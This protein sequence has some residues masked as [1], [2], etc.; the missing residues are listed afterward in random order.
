[1]TEK[2]KCVQGLL[3]NA[4]YDKELIN[5]RIACKD[6]CLEYNGLKNSDADGRRKA[7]EKIIG[8]IKENICIE[9]SFWC[10]YGYNIEVGENFYA[11]HN[12]IILD[13]AKVKFGDNVFIG[14]NCSFYTAGHPLDVQQRNEGLE[15]AHPI[16]VGNNV[17]FGG[18]VVVLPGVSIGNNSVI[19]AGSVVTKD[20][21]DN[22][23]A[24][25][26]PCK[27]IKHSTGEI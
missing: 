1:M 11:N 17:W 26:N 23:V 14:P 5:E 20:I 2:E 19:G 13:C 4:N 15:Y 21:P 18:N 12:L 8:N 16:T 25:G 10:D 27:I 6:L 22:V 24:V 7:L 3:Y 9:P